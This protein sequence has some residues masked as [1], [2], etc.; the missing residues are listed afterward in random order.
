MRLYPLLEIFWTQEYTG[1]SASLKWNILT[2][3][4]YLAVI[5]FSATMKQI[6]KI[7]QSASGTKNKLLKYA[8]EVSS[9]VSIFFL[10]LTRF[11][12][13]MKASAQKPLLKESRRTQFMSLVSLS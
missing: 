13:I 6:L 4:I 10:K 5:G 12:F 8:F 11:R 7:R 1:N 2:N 9:N 3:S